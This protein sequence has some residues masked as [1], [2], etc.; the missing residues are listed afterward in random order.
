MV[1]FSFD[2]TS[3]YAAINITATMHKPINQPF[4]YNGVSLLSSVGPG[5]LIGGFG[6]GFPIGCFGSGFSIGVSGPGF[7][8]GGVIPSFEDFNNL[9]NSGSSVVNFSDIDFKSI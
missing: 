2:G 4:S 9:F 8:I 3:K 5:V 6:S 1:N 7:S